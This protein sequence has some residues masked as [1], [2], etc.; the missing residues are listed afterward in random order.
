MEKIWRKNRENMYKNTHEN[1]DSIQI[2][3]VRKLVKQKELSVINLN[4][5]LFSP[6]FS[7]QNV[8]ISQMLTMCFCHVEVMA[9]FEIQFN[10]K[11]QNSSFF[12][13]FF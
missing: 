8:S 13:E 2:S 9:S 10:S 5:W 6:T 7:N 4:E 11:E 3:K 12:K 1:V